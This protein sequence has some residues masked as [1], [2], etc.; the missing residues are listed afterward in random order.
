M[1]REVLTRVKDEGDLFTCARTCRRWSC[2]A[3]DVRRR[4]WPD[5]RS[6]FLSGFFIAKSSARSLFPTPASVFGRDP[7]LLRSFFPNA[8][9]GLLKRAT[10]LAAC[11]G[12][13]LVRLPSS[14][15]LLHLAVCNLLAGTSD[16][17]P[18]LESDWR[19]HDSGYA[20]FTS[21]DCSSSSE[22]QS[23]PPP[24]GY[25]VLF[26]V[27]VICSNSD[28]QP[29]TLHTFSYSKAMWNAPTEIVSDPTSDGICGPLM[30]HNAVVCHGTAHWLVGWNFLP[31]YDSSL[32]T[33]D[34]DAETCQVSLTK[35]VSPI[36]SN[37]HIYDEPQLS[38]A[39]NGALS[40][41]YMERPG[42]N[43]QGFRLK[44]C[45]RKD[46]EKSEDDG[47]VGWLYSRVVE[48]KLPNQIR[49]EGLHLTFLGEKGGMVVVRDNYMDFYAA[50]L[51]TGVM[52]KLMYHSCVSR[53]MF[54]PFEIYWP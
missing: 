21:A 22:Q 54:I 47:P 40:L 48:L 45:T 37:L 34:V 33:I 7:R 38:V 43:V 30:H 1:V 3:A 28:H 42:N 35:I 19:Y 20:I 17:L 11:H 36:R 8:A 6:S 18:P 24:R 46:D 16:I 5:H 14:C 23:S 10:P 29:C 50:D 32:H 39:A 2:L 13:L 51:E 26:K 41:I 25:S 9:R 49:A 12:L 44:I 15:A 4:R 52:E 53:R 31:P 27:L